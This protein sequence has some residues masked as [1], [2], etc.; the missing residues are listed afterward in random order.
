LVDVGL[1]GKGEGVVGIEGWFGGEIQTFDFRWRQ[2]RH[3]ALVCLRFVLEIFITLDVGGGV[4][5]LDV[6]V[7]ISRGCVSVRVFC[8]SWVGWS[9]ICSIFISG[10]TVSEKKRYRK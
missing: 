7:V 8:M 4:G 1:L 6:L 10:R 5:E 2:A 3:A 9:S